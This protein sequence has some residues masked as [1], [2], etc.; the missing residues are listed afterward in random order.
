MAHMQ[1]LIP[2]CTTKKR[3]REIPV[4]PMTN[5]LP[6]EEVKSSDHFIV[7]LLIVEDEAITTGTPGAFWT[8]KF[9]TGLV[10][11]QFSFTFFTGR[12]TGS[13]EIPVV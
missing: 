3:M 4:R 12:K 8:R 2:T 1:A 7:Y 11:K 9:T 10:A 13:R 6:T 5:F